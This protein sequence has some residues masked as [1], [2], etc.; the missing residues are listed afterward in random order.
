MQV[1][2]RFGYVVTVHAC[3]NY[4]ILSFVPCPS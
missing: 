1:K 4:G 2:V 3:K